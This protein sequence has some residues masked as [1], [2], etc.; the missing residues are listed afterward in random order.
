ML[1]ILASTSLLLSTVIAS[2]HPGA[3]ATAE[4][5]SDR[6][7]PRP[8]QIILIRHAEKPANDND[9]HLSKAGRAR[10]QRL[11]GYLAV[12]PE[13]T[14][15]GKPV[16]VFATATNRH[17]G[18]VRTQET[19]APFAASLRLKVR[20][21]FLGQD[22]AKLAKAIL[23]DAAFAGKTIIICWRHEELAE[24]A[25]A[26]GV[27]PVPPEWKAGNYESVWII[28]YEG[29]NAHLITQAEP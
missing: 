7:D 25:G 24:L 8:A 5:R 17:D 22:Y 4:G 15:F 14:K 23:N 28:R 1:R 12:D 19:I 26:L 11:V 29:N 21:P 10:A 20:T 9:P 3:L 6:S 27:Q 16:A 13:I 2:V 18:G